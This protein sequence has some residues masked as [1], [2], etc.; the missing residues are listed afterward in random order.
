MRMGNGDILKRIGEAKISE[1]RKRTYRAV[2]EIPAGET[3]TYGELARRIGCG[4]ARAVGQALK[5]NPFAPEV[6]C[7]RVVAAGGRLG[8]YFGQTEGDVVE[9]KRRLLAEEAARTCQGRKNIVE[10]EGNE[11]EK[12]NLK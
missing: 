10:T 2:L 1:F 8:G 12:R 3:V 6:P 5:R 4:S 7:H 11:P 9:M